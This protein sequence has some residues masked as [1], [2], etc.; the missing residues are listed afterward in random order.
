LGSIVEPERVL[1]KQIFEGSAVVGEK[2]VD[3]IFRGDPRKS[4]NVIYVD[5]DAETPR[6]ARFVLRDAW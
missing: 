4:G 6:L 5:A 1:E 2:S 3:K